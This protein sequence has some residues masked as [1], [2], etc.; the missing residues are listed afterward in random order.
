MKNQ[1]LA[2]VASFI[3]MAFGCSVEENG[4]VLTVR[5]K[6]NEELALAL[7]IFYFDGENY[8]TITEKTARFA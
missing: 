6:E 5:A 2:L 4:V 3:A 1:T 8:T 7:P